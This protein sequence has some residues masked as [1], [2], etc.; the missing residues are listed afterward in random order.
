MQIKSLRLTSDNRFSVADRASHEA[1]ARLKPLERL[2]KLKA[3]RCAE[4]LCLHP[5]DGSKAT[6]SRWGKRYR[7][8]GIRGLEARSCRP[9]TQRRR[10]GTQQH[11][12]AVLDLRKCHPLQGKPKIGKVLSRDPGFGPGISTIGRIPE[13]LLTSGRVRPLALPWASKS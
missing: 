4:P 5:I 9:Q 6:Y 2:Q 10:Q 12:Q 8:Q 7:K 13:Q 11:Q 3:E 1:R